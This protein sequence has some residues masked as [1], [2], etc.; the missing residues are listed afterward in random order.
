VY[1][2]CGGPRSSGYFRDAETGL[3]YAKARYHQPGM[4]RFLT[5]DPYMASGGPAD[6]G[7]WNRYA[8]VAGDPINFVD[9]RGMLFEGTNSCEADFCADGYG[10]GSTCT[11]DEL[12]TGDC[13][14]NH[15]L[16]PASEGNLGGGGG[17]GSTINLYGTSSTPM[18]VTN[19]SNS[20]AKENTITNVF[21]DIE[22]AL[23][24]NSQCANW[25]QSGMG[26]GA[27]VIQALIDNNLYGYGN[28]NVN[29][30]AAFAGS[31]NAD[32]SSAGVPAGTSITVNSN[33]AFF[34]ATNGSGLTYTVGTQS[35][36]GGTLQAQATILIHELAHVLGV[37][38]FLSDAGN[39]ANG[40]LNDQAVNKNCGKLIGG[41]K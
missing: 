6:P 20:G 36:T 35:Y 24:S 3:D 19:F 34:N 39:A 5:P 31:V 1:D 13:L 30:V 37:A 32:G 12:G 4:G 22:N 8:Y 23:S 16:D 7:S 41:L 11:I 38:G 18:K 33:G 26:T 10:Y 17:G 2:F 15:I 27:T 40:A 14:N 21:Q 25:L 28:F 9:P 29:T